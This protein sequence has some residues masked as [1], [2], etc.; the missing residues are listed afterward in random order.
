M[1]KEGRKLRFRKGKRE[2]VMGGGERVK[3]IKGRIERERGGGG[4]A[5]LR[6]DVI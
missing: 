6:I 2:R 1:K 5:Y 4:L 3:M